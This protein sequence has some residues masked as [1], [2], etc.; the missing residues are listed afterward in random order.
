MIN[1][2][3]YYLKIFIEYVSEVTYYN[4][5]IMARKNPYFRSNRFDSNDLAYD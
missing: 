3:K 5:F 2:I 1:N 4:E